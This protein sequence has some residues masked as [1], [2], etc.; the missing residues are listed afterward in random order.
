MDRT[1]IWKKILPGFIPIFVFVVADEIWGTFPGLIVA[2][3]T[4]ILQL[5]W[6]GVREKRF[7][8]FI[9]FDTLLLVLLGV[10]S[11]ALENDIFFKLKPGFLGMILLSMLGVSAFTSFDILR[12]I[13]RRY[14]GDISFSAEQAAQMKK[15]LKILF[16]ILLFHT[17]LVFYSAFYL[18]KEAWA[19]ISGGLLYLLFGLFFIVQWTKVRKQN[20]L[21]E[22]EE[23]LPLVDEEGRITGKAARS[24][25]HNGSRL[26]HPVVHL[27]VISRQR[28]VLLQKRP[29]SKMIQPGKWDTAVGGHMAADETVET[30]LKREAAEE[31]GLKEFSTRFIRKYKWK[32]TIENE[33]VYMFITH[34]T[35]GVAVQSEEVEEIRFWTK[36]EIERSIGSGM[37]TPNFE[38][39]FAI[40]KKTALI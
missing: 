7:D 32:S 40:L 8:K 2:V 24:V 36:N 27:H 23:W 18:S 1:G 37:L 3:S 25:V 5:T 22:G 30:A 10:V 16:W 31:I 14:Y 29:M 33:L 11:L 26:L 21:P 6:A 39:E 9:L 20:R 17:A 34:D 13:S 15:N 19:F 12:L 35:R 38:F 28:A 4:G